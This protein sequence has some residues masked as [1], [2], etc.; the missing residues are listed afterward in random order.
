MEILNDINWAIIAPFL[1]IQIILMIIALI[2]WI[3]NEQTNGPR[4]MWLL[5]ILIV[6]MIGPVLYFI[7]GRRQD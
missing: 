1:V 2:D 3:K 5:L 6:S 4:W 7:F